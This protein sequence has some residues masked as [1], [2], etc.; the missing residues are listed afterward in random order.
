M[1]SDNELEEVLEN[2]KKQ[3]PE[4]F[5]LVFWHD[6]VREIVMEMLEKKKKEFFLNRLSHMDPKSLEKFLDILEEDKKPKP[7]PIV[8]E[9]APPVEKKVDDK[10]KKGRPRKSHSV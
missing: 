3:F 5:T 9:V 2:L 1:K 4:N 7:E 6:D 8:E 10:P